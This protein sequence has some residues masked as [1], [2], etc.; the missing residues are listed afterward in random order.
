MNRRWVAVLGATSTILLVPLLAAGCGTQ[1]EEAL[2]VDVAA[3]ADH[4]EAA[5]QVLSRVLDLPAEDIR[6][7]SVDE[8]LLAGKEY[9][10]AL[11]WGEGNGKGTALV[12]SSTGE[13]ITI[14]QGSGL[15]GT[16]P[17]TD[18]QIAS[19]E[20]AAE[21]AATAE[22]IIAQLGWS[23]ERLQKEGYEPYESGV[24]S[25]EMSQFTSTWL[26]YSD[27]GIATG[28]GIEVMLDARNGS[29]VL[30]DYDRGADPTEVDL[31]RTMDQAEAEAIA[32]KAIEGLYADT[33]FDVSLLGITKS[34]MR[35][36]KARG[37]ADGEQRLIWDIELLYEGEAYEI[38]AG[39]LAYIDAFTGEIL[40]LSGI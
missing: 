7:A 31:S 20:S 40:S 32:K 14:T 3:A 23:P 1:T 9:D 36:I 38:A 22:V 12:D 18:E 13:I 28:G 17:M 37:V 25:E 10:T 8:R 21:L 2:R 30:Y 11:E 27:Q 35:W 34:E 24:T 5:A 39:G 33:S 16:F 29:L 4:S 19:F 26:A 6:I 15:E